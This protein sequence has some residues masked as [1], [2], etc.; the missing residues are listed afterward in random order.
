MKKDIITY[1]KKDIMTYWPFEYPPR[2]SQET[3]LKWLQ[4]QTAK[5][6]II[7]APVGSGKS[8]LGIT[9]SMFLHQINPDYKGD[10]FIITPQKILQ[11]QYMSSFVDEKEIAIKTLYGKSNYRCESKGMSCEVGN[12]I[13]PKCPNCPHARARNQV[14]KS[15]HAVLNYRLALTAF[16]YTT[17]FK[18][19]SLMI[20]DECHNLE[21]NLVDFDALQISE[22]KCKRY[23]IDWKRCKT[24]SE[25]RTWIR[26]I[27][28]PKIM[29]ALDNLRVECDEIADRDAD[30]I[31]KTDTKKLKRYK[32]LEN[33]VD[34]VSIM[35]VR[36]D[37]YINEN[38]VLVHDTTMFE[39]KRITGAYSFNNIIKPKAERFL[40]MSSTILDKRGFCND[41]GIPENETAFLSVDS[42]FP[43][44]NRPIFYMPQTKMN[45]S[46]NSPE[47][48]PSRKAMLAKLNELLTKHKGEKGIIHTGNFK[49]AEWVVKE[50]GKLK[51]HTLYHHNPSS[52]I[53][54][55]TAINNFLNDEAPSILISPSCTEGL[56]LKYDLGRFAIFVKCP[57][58]NLGDQ[59]IKR[60]MELSG[61]WYRRRALIDIIQGGGRI[62]RSEDDIGTV[63]ILD[64]SFGYLFTQTS[65]MIPSWWKESYKLG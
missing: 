51:S 36:T 43:V 30:E 25:A 15:P 44:A 28:L 24:V 56:D 59:W 63:Y 45:V 16:A 23:N 27:Y 58:G 9:Y 39:F 17:V 49:I 10:A 48:E 53:D 2:K 20:L 42:E 31:T 29:N 35:S 47:R 46:W 57:F 64:Q 41:L 14:V 4:E 21:S 37:G 50:L 3:A 13:S 32:E 34:E 40:F 12:I 60:R 62:V 5:Y 61:A 52:E 54:R 6:L 22:W 1:C 55:D 11:E 38:F 33:H 65:H 18:R 8:N 26:D 19:R 7:E